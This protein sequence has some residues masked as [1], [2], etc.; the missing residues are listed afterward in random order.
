MLLARAKQ[1]FVCMKVSDNE[2]RLIKYQATKRE[3][4][5]S[6]KYCNGRITASSFYDVSALKGSPNKLINKLLHSPDLC[7]I[8]QLNWVLIVKMWL[9]KSML[10]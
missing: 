1:I 3:S 8:Q 2:S 9:D 5:Y 4:D 6:F 10:L 7:K